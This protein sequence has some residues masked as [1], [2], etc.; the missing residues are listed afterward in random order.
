MND[1]KIETGNDMEASVSQ[2]KDDESFEQTSSTSHVQP[3]KTV[4]SKQQMKEMLENRR[5]KKT[6]KQLKD[7]KKLSEEVIFR[8]A[9]LDR[10]NKQD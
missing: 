9:M 8:H 10:M 3:N 1:E 7:P 2:E 4:P 6:T 5:Y